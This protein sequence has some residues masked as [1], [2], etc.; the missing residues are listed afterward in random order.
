MRA[1]VLSGG[2]SHGAFQVGALDYLIN[3]ANLSYD[4]L[5]GISVGSLNGSFLSMYPT[6]QEKQAIL[7]LKKFWLNLKT[8]NVYKN[9]FPFG[10]IHALW[11]NSA[12]NSQPLID[13]S[14]KTILLDK[15]RKSGKQISVGAVS[16][17]TGKYCNFTQNNDNFVDCMLAS[18]AFPGALKPIN[19]NNEL[20]VDGGVKHESPVK[21]AIELGATSIDAIICSP[22]Q[23]TLPYNNSSNTI[24]L[25]VR[26][27]NLMIEQ[28]T[29]NDLQLANLYNKL[30]FAG[31]CHDKKIIDINVIRPSHDLSSDFLDFKIEGITECMAAGYNAAKI[32]F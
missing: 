10:A 19:I 25:G 15:I 23:T 17:N 26:S 13:L 8:E 22:S 4:I 11:K 5:I 1:L 27:I 24:T 18:S 3:E 29:E 20:W 31:A 16:L 28:L 7:D 12:Y 6:T 14:R 21:R 32:K 2:G 30:I 9:W